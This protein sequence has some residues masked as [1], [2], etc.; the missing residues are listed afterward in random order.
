MILRRTVGKSQNTLNSILR[1]LVR[2]EDG[3]AAAEFAIIVPVLG[4][5]LVG[6]VDLA[7]LANTGS[8]L[9]A[10]VR[11][12]ADYALANPTNTAGVTSRV[13]N[14]V[15]NWAGSTPTVTFPNAET[16][17]PTPSWHPQF[18]TCD[19]DSFVNGGTITCDNDTG[20]NG[21]GVLCVSGPKHV[22]VTIRAAE[23][24]VAWLLPLTGIALPSSTNCASGSVCR[25]LTVRVL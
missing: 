8:V 4:F 17:S 1:R 24:G 15:M 21:A 10:A 7:N 22:Y 14:Y 3:A 2:R 5:L 16:G 25:S 19:G 9:D 13:Q 18:C 6:T 20:E 23:T 11:A 12:G